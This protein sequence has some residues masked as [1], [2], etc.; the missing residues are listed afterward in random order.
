M[1]DI[2]L[3]KEE[4]KVIEKFCNSLSD[5]TTLLK[6]IKDNIKNAKRVNEEKE[7]RVNYLK[8]LKNRRKK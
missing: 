3:T 1:D 4:I 2:I 8:S 5:E 7:K 6:N